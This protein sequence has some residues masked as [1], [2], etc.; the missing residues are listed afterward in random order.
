MKTIVCQQARL[1]CHDSGSHLAGFVL[2]VVQIFPVKR[3]FSIYNLTKAIL[4]KSD[5]KNIFCSQSIS[6]HTYAHTVIPQR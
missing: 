4:D 6:L 1:F 5:L 3:T 2:A